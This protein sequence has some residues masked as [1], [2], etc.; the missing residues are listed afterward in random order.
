MPLTILYVED[1]KVVAHV[2]RETS[3]AEGWC[4]VLCYDGAVAVK[5]LASAASYDLLLFDNDL[6]NVSGLE[7]VRYAREFPHRT[8]TT[9]I[10]LSAGACRRDARLAGANEFLRK[11][12]DIGKI[13]ETVTPL[14]TS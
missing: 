9:I 11:P 2:V 4:V 8:Q 12:E 6:P 14:L 10:V 5:R 3:K 7:L 1:H 13:V